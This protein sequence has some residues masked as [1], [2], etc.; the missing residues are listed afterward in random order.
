MFVHLSRILLICF[1]LVGFAVSQFQMRAYCM[2][3]YLLLRRKQNNRGGAAAGKEIPISLFSLEIIILGFFFTFSLICD[4]PQ[5]LNHRRFGH[6]VSRKSRILLFFFVVVT[7]T[8]CLMTPTTTTAFPPFHPSGRV[9][10]PN[11]T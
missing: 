5:E 9:F 7:R 6:P 11:W 10:D 3:V 4:I 2:P 8:K 1:S